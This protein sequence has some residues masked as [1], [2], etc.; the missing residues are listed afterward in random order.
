MQEKRNE[1]QMQKFVHKTPFNCQFSFG[2][3]NEHQKMNIYNDN[4]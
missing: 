3:I 4:S 1:L 2:E